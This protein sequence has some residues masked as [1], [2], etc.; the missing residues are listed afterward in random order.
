MWAIQAERVRRRV[1]AVQAA[2]V[3][4]STKLRP[5]PRITMPAMEP[6][7]GVLLSDVPQKVNERCENDDTRRAYV[8]CSGAA[9][10]RRR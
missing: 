3:R 7:S 9:S 2:F 1:L 6:E 4:I 5:K 10:R 8:Y